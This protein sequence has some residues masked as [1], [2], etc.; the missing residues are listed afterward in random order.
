MTS[1]AKVWD[2]D[3]NVYLIRRDDFFPG[4]HIE[5]VRVI[6]GKYRETIYFSSIVSCYAV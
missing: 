6:E 1:Y 4:R 5:V 2:K 3:G